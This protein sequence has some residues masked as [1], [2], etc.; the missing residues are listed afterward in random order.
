MPAINAAMGRTLAETIGGT[1]PVL[2]TL[3]TTINDYAYQH[4][5]LG[6]RDWLWM[7]FRML[8]AF[9]ACCAALSGTGARWRVPAMLRP[10]TASARGRHAT[11]LR[12]GS[13]TGWMS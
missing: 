12:P 3:L 6:C 13:W 8:P 11:R 5:R 4:A 2:T 9:L 1:A 7:L 10:W